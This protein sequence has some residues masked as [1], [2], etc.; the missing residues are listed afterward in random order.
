MSRLRRPAAVAVAGIAALSAMV[1]A[2]QAHSV[3]APAVVSHEVSFQVKNTNDTQ[4]PCPTDGATYSIHGRL[5]GPANQLSSDNSNRSVV[6]S[7]HGLGYGEFFWDF[8]A[9]PGY[10]WSAALAEHGVASVVIDRK[11]VV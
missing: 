3:A 5:V 9:V 10:D 1:A 8:D 2:P 11:S 6:L 4:L 7:L